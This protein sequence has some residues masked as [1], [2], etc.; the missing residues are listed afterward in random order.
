MCLLTLKISKQ[1]SGT[2]SSLTT[3]V[4]QMELHTELSF[5]LD[6]HKIHMQVYHCVS[7]PTV[8][9]ILGNPIIKDL[10]EYFCLL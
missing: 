6:K 1:Q 9:K 8:C 3:E 10:L 7:H 4:L 2:N 5:L